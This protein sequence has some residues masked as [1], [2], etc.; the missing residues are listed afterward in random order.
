MSI[1]TATELQAVILDYIK[2]INTW[3]GQVPYGIQGYTFIGT[4]S[5]PVQAVPNVIVRLLCVTDKELPGASGL[6]IL[7]YRILTYPWTKALSRILRDHDT[8]ISFRYVPAVP[9][10][11]TY[12]NLPNLLSLSYTDSEISI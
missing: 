8:H 6:R 5:L 2:Y 1:Q 4:I 11:P 9:Y 10:T 12:I 7:T 3:N